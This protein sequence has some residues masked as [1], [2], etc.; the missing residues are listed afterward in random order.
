MEKRLKYEKYNN[1]NDVIMVDLHN[2]YTAIAI[3]GL[4]AEN[5][6]TTTLFIKEN[7]IDNWMLCE[8]TE[9]LEIE[10]KPQ[11]LNSAILKQIAT[12]YK[13]RFFDYYIKRYEFEQ[14]AF[15]VG[16]ELIKERLD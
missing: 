2:G 13:D 3:T 7:S 16:H 12:L 1:S 14:A 9:K 5:T 11:F 8:K 6:Y 10:S 4:K 15:K